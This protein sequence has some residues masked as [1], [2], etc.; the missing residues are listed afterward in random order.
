MV[1]LVAVEDFDKYS[2]LAAVAR[3]NAIWSFGQVVATVP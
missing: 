3:V 1:S 2:E